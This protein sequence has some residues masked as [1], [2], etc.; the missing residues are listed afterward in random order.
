MNTDYTLPPELADL[1]HALAIAARP[2]TP[3]R[4]GLLSDV[5]RA[6]KLGQPLPILEFASTANYTYNKRA[7]AMRA[8]FDAGKL[9]ELSAIECN[10]ANTYARALRRYR[11]LLVQRLESDLAN[12]AAVEQEPAA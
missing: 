1:L 7:D 3:V 2:E 9:A 6:A 10:G 4:R 11:E 5:E 8:L 12:A